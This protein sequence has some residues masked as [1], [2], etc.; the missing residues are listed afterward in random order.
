MPLF[1]VCVIEEER[2]ATTVVVTSF[3]RAPDIGETIDLPHGQRITVRHLVSS[4]D[5]VIGVITA[6]PVRGVERAAVV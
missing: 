2:A 6:T 1:R 5:E 3:D 4:Q